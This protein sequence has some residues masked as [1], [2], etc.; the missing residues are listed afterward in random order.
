MIDLSEVRTQLATVAALRRVAGAAEF[1]A[2]ANAHP[3]AGPAAYVMLL[4]ES[5]GASPLANAMLQRVEVSIGIALAVRN[6]ADSTGAA[7]GDAL[8]DLRAAMTAALLG[9]TPTDAE[10][11]Y[12]GQGQLLAFKDGWLWWQDIWHTA[13]YERSVL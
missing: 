6:V 7:A 13:Y 5:P 12:R 3:L 2:A 8:D 11:L 9:W 1:Q 4:G 10:P